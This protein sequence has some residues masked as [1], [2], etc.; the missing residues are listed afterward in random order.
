MLNYFDVDYETMWRDHPDSI[1]MGWPEAANKY[2]AYS[3]FRVAQARAAAMIRMG[4][5]APLN[6]VM[7]G[8]VAWTSRESQ[9][10]DL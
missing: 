3:P 6:R 10:R 4:V 8:I 7:D 5:V 1:D 9:C 2:W